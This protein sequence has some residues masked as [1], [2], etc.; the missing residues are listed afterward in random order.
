MSCTSSQRTDSD[1]ADH[2]QW[3]RHSPARSLRFHPSERA[4]S[5][6]CGNPMTDDHLITQFV[7]LVHPCCYEAIGTPLTDPF[8]AREEEVRR[9][10]VE[11]IRSL[12][13]S[14]FVVQ[15]DYAQNP[16]ANELHR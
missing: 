6:Q 12:A 15:I 11:A 16:S 13:L 8:R 14:T 9:R 3:A 7:I 10:W 2:N 1:L 5:V 4:I